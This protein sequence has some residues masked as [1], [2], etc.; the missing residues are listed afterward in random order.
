HDTPAPTISVA[1]ASDGVDRP[2]SIRRTRPPSAHARPMPCRGRSRSPPTRPAMIIVACTAPKS[3]SAPV[4]AGRLAEAKGD[5]AAGP[6]GGE[7][8]G[9]AS[10]ARRRAAAR[11]R[12]E[13]EGD[14]AR[15]DADGGERRRIDRR[16]AQR[17]PA[18]QGVGGEGD[19]REGREGEGP[20][21]G[22][23]RGSPGGDGVGSLP[24]GATA[25]YSRSTGA[26]ANGAGKIGGPGAPRAVDRLQWAAC[27][28]PG[29]SPS[30][31]AAPSPTSPSPTRP[32]APRGWPRRRRRR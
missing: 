15:D 29:R 32:P 13:P 5:P 17:R 31:W 21:G 7:R 10:P 9:P 18:E 4:P 26:P 12:D 23:R 30:T 20:C 22:H 24:P 2:G 14:G 19:H 25:D 1:P 16:V 3:S 27:P 11:P 6:E 8:R 28:A